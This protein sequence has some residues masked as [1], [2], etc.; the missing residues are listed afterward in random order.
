[1]IQALSRVMLRLG[2]WHIE[3]GPPPLAKYVLIAAPHTSNWDFIWLLACAGYYGMPIRW[4]GKHTLFRWPYG[5]IMRL[6]GGI[7]VR[8]DRRQSLVRQMA[9]TLKEQSSM[10]L[11]VPVEGTRGRVSHWKSGFYHIAR[12]AGVPIVMSYLDYGTKR[13]GIGPVLE[14]TGNVSR[15]MDS[16]RAFYADKVGKFPENTSPIRLVEENAPEE[17]PADVAPLLTP[18][19]AETVAIV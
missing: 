14:P 18:A 13:C 16:L 3:G 1:M 7:S 17:A 2:G 12:T 4:I 15:D 11:V 19:A 6:L 10:I 8:R 9:D 5:W